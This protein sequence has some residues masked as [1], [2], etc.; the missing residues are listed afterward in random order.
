MHLTNMQR[1]ITKLEWWHD[2]E[3]KAQSGGIRYYE[4]GNK[5]A[6]AETTKRVSWSRQLRIAEAKAITSHMVFGNF[7]FA[8]EHKK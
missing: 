6:G 3:D 8:G 2:W 5:G 7:S 1:N 4:Y